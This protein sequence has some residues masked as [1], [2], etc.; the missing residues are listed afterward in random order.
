MDSHAL[1]Y[2][3]LFPDLEVLSYYSLYNL[4]IPFSFS[5][6]Y[7]N[8]IM[9]RKVIIMLSY[10][11]HTL[12]SFLFIFSSFECIFSNNL[13]SI[14][15][16]FIVWLILPL[17][18]FHFYSIHCILHCVFISFMY[19]SVLEYLIDFLGFQ[20]V[21]FSFFIYCFPDFVKKFFLCLL[22]SFAEIP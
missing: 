19:S 11:S 15:E 6:R 20:S 9:L 16:V 2:L 22:L 5:T 4:S 14:L 21:A 8:S 17:T 1:A 13:F 7:L 18:L 10:K 12:S 3:Y